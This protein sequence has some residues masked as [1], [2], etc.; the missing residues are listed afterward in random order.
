M[1]QIYPN[2]Y[3]P[4]DYTYNICIGIIFGSLIYIIITILILIL[5]N[6]SIEEINN[7]TYTN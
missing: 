4:D 2:N 6:I 7:S 5:I 3:V 1:N